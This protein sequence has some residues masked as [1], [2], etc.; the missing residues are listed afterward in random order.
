MDARLRISETPRKTAP[1][2]SAETPLVTLAWHALRAEHQRQAEAAELSRDA[3]VRIA[4]EV[5]RL[6][7][8]AVATT[9]PEGGLPVVHSIRDSADRIEAALKELGITL[10][11]EER[12]PFAGELTEVLD[13]VA[14]IP[15]TDI[16]LPL[17][18]E[19]IEP[20]ILWNETLL[21]RGKAVIAIPT[22]AKGDRAG[23]AE[24]VSDK[25]PK[26]APD[27]EEITE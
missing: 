17:V 19:I 6:R 22:A 15:Q 25:T 2:V 10:L 5:A 26:C 3:L 13:N 1:G 8:A 18:A 14:Q 27:G 7:R 16:D 11:G 12:L 4:E 21:R 23:P 20:A 9:S 24:G